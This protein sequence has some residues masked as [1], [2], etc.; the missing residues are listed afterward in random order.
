MTTNLDPI[1]LSN[2][3]LFKTL[4]YDVDGVTPVTPTSCSISLW[5]IA[6]GAAVLTNQ[7]GSVGSGYAQYNW[8]GSAT[9][10]TFQ[11]VLTVT[12]SSGVI[13]SE[14][15]LVEVLGK[16]PVYN[17]ILSPAEASLTLRCDVGD[18]IM[19]Q[20]LPQ[21]DNYLEYATGHK[22]ASDASIHPTAKSAAGLALVYWYDNPGAVGQTPDA[23]M[24]L[25]IQLEGEALKYRKYQFSG[26]TGA[27]AIWL[28]GAREGDVVMKLTGV[29]GVS[30]DQSSK[31]ESTISAEG[32][33]LQTNAS[34][35]SDNQYVV[36]LKHPAD[37]VSG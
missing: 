8:S 10:G 22:W 37:D 20:L 12:I 23:L 11:A 34:D 14:H 3:Q 2:S 19:L 4:V 24:S 9:A 29:V 17:T 13:K 7:A 27:G 1:Y 30:G 15:F 5:N 36:V 33:I 32:Q 16:P 28:A 18:Q 25:L 31:F 35:L 6:T 26:L 21:I